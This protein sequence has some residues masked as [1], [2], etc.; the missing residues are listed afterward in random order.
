MMSGAQSHPAPVAYDLVFTEMKTGNELI[1]RNP[2]GD[3]EVI[4]TEFAD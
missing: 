3:R 1:I 2:E 4:L